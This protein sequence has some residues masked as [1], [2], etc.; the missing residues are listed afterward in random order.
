MQKLIHELTSVNKFYIVERNDMALK[1]K[2]K[3]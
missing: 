3:T 2:K 1:D